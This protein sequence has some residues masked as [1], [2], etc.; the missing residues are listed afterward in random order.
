MGSTRAVDGSDGQR[1]SAYWIALVVSDFAESVARV[2]SNHRFMS[3]SS[4]TIAYC[5]KNSLPPSKFACPLSRPTLQ[6]S[7]EVGR[8]G[9]SDEHCDIVCAEFGG[10]QIFDGE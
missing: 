7:A 8:I 5:V 3:S 2:A 10:L 6:R 9:E 1:F 4:G